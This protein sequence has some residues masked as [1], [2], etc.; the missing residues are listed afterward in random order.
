MT[1]ELIRAEFPQV[2]HLKILWTNHKVTKAGK[3]WIREDMI[4]LFLYL[5][6]SLKAYQKWIENIS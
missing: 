5:L 4:Y 6:L 1:L 2:G 3:Q